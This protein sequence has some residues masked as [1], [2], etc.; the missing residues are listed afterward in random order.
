MGRIAVLGL[1]AMGTALAAPLAYAVEPP[2]VPGI[3][4]APRGV[5]P[6]RIPPRPAPGVIPKRIPPGGIGLGPSVVRPG[7]IGPNCRSSCGSR[8]Q[9]VT[10][11]GLNVSQCAA[12]RQ[13][14]RMSCTT[15]C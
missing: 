4:P 13:R 3:R 6:Q 9:M 10:C 14:C 15:R 8:C 7:T 11:S 2:I 12:A 1:L 5:A